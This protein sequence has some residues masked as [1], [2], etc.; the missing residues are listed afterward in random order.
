MKTSEFRTAEECIL[1]GEAAGG[2]EGEARLF[3]VYTCRLYPSREQMR[4]V[5]A[6]R[7]ADA[8]AREVHSHTLQLV[9]A[10]AQR[11]WS[12]W[13]KRGRR[14]NGPRLREPGHVRSFGFKQVNNGFKVD[15]RRLRLFGVGR[16]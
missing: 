10:D 4:E 2:A 16:V 11:A 5:A 7:A 15:G 12:A 9:V 14:G 8:A 6:F 13:L 3:R 1:S